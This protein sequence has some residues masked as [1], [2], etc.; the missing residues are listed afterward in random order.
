MFK[1]YN[2]IVLSLVLLLSA[3]SEE[4]RQNKISAEKEQLVPAVSVKGQALTFAHLKSDHSLLLVHSYSNGKT[5]A[6][7]L[8][9]LGAPKLPDMLDAITQYG[10]ENIKEIAASTS[11]ESKN[12]EIGEFSAAASSLGRHISSGTNFIEHAEETNSD[13]VFHYPKFSSA[14]PPVSNVKH[15]KGVLLD[16][17]VE[18]CMRA[19]R[20]IANL[21][22]FTKAN[23]F[24]FLC[25]DFSDRS[26]LS[27]YIDPD[28][29][30]SGSAFTRAK[31]GEDYF[32]SGPF[33]V[34]PEDWRGFVSNERI[35]T[36]LNG[37][38]R[39]DSR[40]RYMI[41]DFKD[42]TKHVLADTTSTRFIYQG[43]GV[44]MLDGERIK[45]GQTL[46]SGTP[47]GVIFMPPTTWQITKG[48]I[49]YVFTLGFL[50][51]HT[52]REAVIESFIKQELKAG[53]FLKHGDQVHYL[54][55]SMG[56]I[57]VTVE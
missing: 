23:K 16:Y 42:I 17:E 3:C 57:H 38:I 5:T 10:L 26:M 11:L 50:G 4:P 43:K 34:L 55:A 31:S 1:F 15:V 35:M 21:D 56:E 49:G 29:Y 32:S 51:E 20:P 13:R 22:D 33:L 52:G 54:S 19:D 36:K 47:E 40:G 44:T 7:N 25:G 24:F 30:D 12:Y 28:N 18:I 27:R 46:M 48:I 9:D 37:T 14:S 6:V 39:Q 8:S 2:L 45:Q 53:R 41:R